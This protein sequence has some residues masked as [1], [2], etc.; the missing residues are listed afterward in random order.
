MS[1]PGETLVLK[2]SL[3]L[4][5]MFLY[6]AA[7]HVKA[8]TVGGELLQRCSKSLSSA[9]LLTCCC[10]TFCMSVPPCRVS[11]VDLLKIA[12]NKALFIW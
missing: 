2:Q 7:W 9:A 11:R 10:G 12:N 5:Q 1:L 6:F 4:M 8:L 3:F